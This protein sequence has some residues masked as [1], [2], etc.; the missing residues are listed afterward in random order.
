MAEDLKVREGHFEEF[1][2]ESVAPDDDFAYW[3]TLK[4]AEKERLRRERF[5]GGHQRG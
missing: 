1:G 2:V 3:V 4:R 5:V